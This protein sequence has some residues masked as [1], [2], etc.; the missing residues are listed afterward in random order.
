M[1]ADVRGG[2]VRADPQPVGSR[3]VDERLE[4]RVG[5]RRRRRMVP[6]AHGNDLGGSI[7]YPAS[8]CG[9]FGS[10]RPGPATRWGRSTAMRSAAGAVEHALTRTV[11]DSAALLDATAWP[12]ARRSVPGAARRRPFLR[13]GR[14]RPRP[15]ADRLHARDTADGEPGHPD[16][17]AALEDAVALCERS[18]TMWARASRR[19]RHRRVGR[20]SARCS[21]PRR[22][23][24]STTGC[25]ASDA[26]P[27]RRART[28]DEAF[29]T[30]GRGVTAGRLPRGV[31]ELQRLRPHGRPA[32]SPASTCGSHR[33]CRRRPLPIGEITSTPDEPLRAAP[34]QRTDGRLRRRARQHHGQPGDVGPA[35]LERRGSADRRAL[36][37]PLR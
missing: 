12:D 13:R 31:E 25:G 30:Q 35:V 36:P 32:C 9:V 22:R 28:T 34:T 21:W 20:R 10:S 4:R 8:A 19:S 3:P 7:R 15:A 17:V 6:T 29:W 27:G 16:C 33:R 1:V 23:G 37:R 26:S 14:R 5:G 18:A 24:S 2:A 11:R